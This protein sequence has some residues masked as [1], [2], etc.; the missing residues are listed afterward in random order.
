MVRVAHCTC[1]QLRADLTGEPEFV[2]ACH[3][4]ACQRRTGALF[5]AGAYCKR[6]QVKLSGE[7][8]TYTRVADSGFKF[9]TY[10]CPTCGTT[11]YWESDRMQGLLGI[12][13]GAFFDPN[14]PKPQRAVYDRS[15]HH[16]LG[17]GA[18]LE[19]Y[20]RGRDGPMTKD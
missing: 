10:F 18:G 11:V 14:F 15:R 12:A 7:S 8:K 17:L 4:E 6:E 19:R 16:W 1:G 20:E 2:V 9:T 13:V 5:G 3:C